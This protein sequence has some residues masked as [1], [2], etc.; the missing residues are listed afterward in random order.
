M[1]AH[2]PTFDE[3]VDR[4]GAQVFRVCRSILR[5]DAEYERGMMWL[6]QGE[7]ERGCDILRDVAEDYEVGHPRR[8]AERTIAERCGGE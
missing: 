2:P 7:T 5:D 4:H 8:E 6:D 3:L 1:S